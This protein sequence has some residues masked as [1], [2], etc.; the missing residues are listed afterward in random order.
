MP[1]VPRAQASGV[2]VVDARRTLCAAL[3]TVVSHP[4]GLLV[5]CTFQT[6]SSSMSRCQR[7]KVVLC[8][9]AVA[10][11]R[12]L[13]ADAHR[14]HQHRHRRGVHRSGFRW[15]YHRPQYSLPPALTAEPAVT[16]AP[17]TPAPVPAPTPAAALTPEPMPAKA[18]AA[19]PEA[20]PAEVSIASL[21]GALPAPS[22]SYYA[23][24][25]IHPP[26]PSPPPSSPSGS[27]IT[28]QTY[29]CGHVGEPCCDDGR[30]GDVC[31]GT[32]VCHNGWCVKNYPPGV[33]GTP[34]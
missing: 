7:N 16:A 6:L 28:E 21:S 25:T 24:E 32:N 18:P 11:V 8:P 19:K 14:R 13:P 4:C 12:L 26:P 31:P 1:L 15:H 10:E 30:N 34:G 5:C 29:A 27:S 17:P 22:P 3:A 2:H 33:V 9:V 20:S 23:E